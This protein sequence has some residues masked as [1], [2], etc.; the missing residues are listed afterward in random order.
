MGRLMRQQ[1][2]TPT[3]LPQRERPKN[4]GFDESG[5]PTDG[6]PFRHTTTMNTKVRKDEADRI[7]RSN[8]VFYD[9]LSVVKPKVLT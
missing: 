3:F 7:N 2:L 6:A 8:S 9:K 4:K 5:Q 1:C